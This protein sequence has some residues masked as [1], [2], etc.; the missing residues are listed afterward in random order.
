MITG[1]GDFE[2]IREKQN[3]ENFRIL[4]LRTLSKFSS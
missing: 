4:E 2:I 1:D 3:D